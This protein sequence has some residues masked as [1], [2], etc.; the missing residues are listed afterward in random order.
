MRADH[1]TVGHRN[2]IFV[3]ASDGTEDFA[4]SAVGTITSHTG[5]YWE[6]E[7]VQLYNTVQGSKDA[8]KTGQDQHTNM[9]VFII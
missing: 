1:N 4:E 2:E 6:E 5:N 9:M 3:Q 7:R 8:A